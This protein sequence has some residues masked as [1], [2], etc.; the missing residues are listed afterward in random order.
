MD[1]GRGAVNWVRHA[2]ER[3]YGASDGAGVVPTFSCNDK[4]KNL[5]GSIPRIVVLHP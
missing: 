4:R 5:D 3:S 1:D 2:E